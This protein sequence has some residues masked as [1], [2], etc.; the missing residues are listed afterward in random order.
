MKTELM[1]TR[2]ETLLE[3]AFESKKH[4]IQVLGSSSEL[5]LSFFLSQT[6][7]KQINNLPH[8]VI[9]SSHASAELLSEL[10]RFFDP[11]KVCHLFNHFDVSPYSG[12]YP[13]ARTVGDRLQFLYRA[14]SAK[15]G[16]IFITSIQALCQKTI[17]FKE[18]KDRTF[19]WRPGSEIP[20]GIAG[21]LNDLGYQSA[22]M[23][24]DQ[25]QYAFRGGIIDIFSPAQSR[26]IR[27][28]LFGDQIESLRFF[29]P[30]DQRSKEETS[31]I[32][33]IPA[34]E[35]LFRDENHEQLLKSF[36]ASLEG[37]PVDRTE[38]EE[39][40]RSLVLKNYFPGAEFLLPYF[41]KNLETAF[42]HFSS[43][44]NVWL[45]DPIE[46]SRFSDE[47][48][49]EM[50]NEYIGADKSVIRPEIEKLFV[51]F[52][53]MQ[54][55]DDSRQIYFSNLEYFDDET[56][57]EV[58]IEYRSSQVTEF[59][60][61]SLSFTPGSDS[62]ISAVKQKLTRW[63]EDGYKVFVGIKNQTQMDRLAH[64]IDR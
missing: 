41:Y 52:D 2:L 61:L 10:I 42:D 55:P 23:V 37:R 58:K 7:S 34:K 33:I 43:A 18:L 48:L 1:H 15:P 5:P 12:L 26:P 16:E 32:A 24:E 45:L 30:A 44:L 59:T 6:Y 17:P 20:D 22:P 39:V 36:R 13:N 64:F 53:K 62:W 21:F 51:N 40:L 4:K 28:E 8:L 50:K 47:H 14:Q 9:T 29:S 25:G 35:I 56:S 54:M 38:S 3:R 46:V 19:V 57:N 11:L 31:F 60:N 63:K 49:A 27:L